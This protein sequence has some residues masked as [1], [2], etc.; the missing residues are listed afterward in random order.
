[1]AASRGT[2]TESYRAT[3]VQAFQWIG[4]RQ[5]EPGPVFVTQREPKPTAMPPPPVAG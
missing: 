4:S 3:P 5:T 2:S 1:M